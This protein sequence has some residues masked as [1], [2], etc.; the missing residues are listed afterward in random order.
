MKKLAIIAENFSESSLCLAKYIAEM[1]VHVDYYRFTG[2]SDNGFSF[3]YDYSR[4]S[5]FFLYHK[6]VKL[7]EIPELAGY[8]KDLP[9]K[10]HLLHHSKLYK[11]IPFLYNYIYKK[12]VKMLQ[13]EGY[14][15][16]NL[17]GGERMKIFHQQPQL[18]RIVHSLHEVG[19]HQ[20]NFES[21]PL[22][23]AIIKDKT[24]VLFFSESTRSRFLKLHD[25]EL[26]K[27][28]VIPFGK[29]ETIRFYD[30]GTVINTG[31][32]LGKRTFMFF[33]YIR[34]YKGLDI[35]AQAM[36]QLAVEK[37]NYNI[38]IAGSG[39]DPCLEFFRKQ[40]NCFVMNRIILNNEVNAL[41]KIADVI[42]MPYKTASQTGIAPTAYLF[43]KPLIATNVGALPDVVVHEKN[44]LLIEPNSS[45]SLSSAMM[46]LIKDPNLL[47]RL[48]EGTKMFGQG[49]MYDWKKIARKTISFIESVMS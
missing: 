34:P 7:N 2:L 46:R 18:P 6:I 43:A 30:D 36:E 13:K 9:F 32:D 22:I 29:F 49:D 27:S 39:D 26:C 35:L 44:G 25:S 17:I 40:H 41:F 8:F 23:E 28:T 45:D 37:D 16:Y 21:T 15:S 10:M 47:L 14:D 38:I 48:S 12:I 42:L 11:M 33:G 3:A 19:S 20:D 31:L 1:G 24:P 4:V 5:N